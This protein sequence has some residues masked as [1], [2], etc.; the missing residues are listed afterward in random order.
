MKVCVVFAFVFI[1]FVGGLQQSCLSMDPETE[2][3]ITVKEGNI[4]LDA[5]NGDLYFGTRNKKS[6]MALSEMASTADVN[7]VVEDQVMTAFDGNIGTNGTLC[8]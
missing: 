1:S 2:P 3:S 4:H 5:P 8:T 6:K 7:N